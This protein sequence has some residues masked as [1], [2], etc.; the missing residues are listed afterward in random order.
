MEFQ[1]S[2]EK[3]KFTANRW[4]ELLFVSFRL[5]QTRR[6][7]YFVVLGKRYLLHFKT[8]ISSPRSISLSLEFTPTT[9]RGRLN[10]Q[11]KAPPVETR[12]IRQPP[13]RKSCF[14]IGSG[15]MVI[16]I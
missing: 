4:R 2:Y 14:R 3:R 1:K 5:D 9:R 15:L 10:L 16:G 8:L 11:Q 12:R 13:R 6:S 7:L